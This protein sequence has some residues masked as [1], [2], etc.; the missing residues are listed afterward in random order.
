M[1]GDSKPFDVEKVKIL[2]DEK[3]KNGSKII[4]DKNDPDP[5]IIKNGSAL[6]TSLD[7]KNWKNQFSMEHRYWAKT[8]E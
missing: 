4:P 5:I 8:R 7:G 1:N 2:Q 3:F 6:V